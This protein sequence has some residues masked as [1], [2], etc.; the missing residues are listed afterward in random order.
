MLYKVPTGPDGPKFS[1]FKKWDIQ[2]YAGTLD[3]QLREKVEAEFAQI[4]EQLKQGE[5]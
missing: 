5:L 2:N 3:Y 4:K 1:L